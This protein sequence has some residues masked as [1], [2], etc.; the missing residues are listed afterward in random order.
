M[1]ARLAIGLAGL[2][3]VLGAA[4]ALADDTEALIA[5][6]KQWGEAGGKGDTATIAKLLADDLV[7]V[8]ETGVRGK[9]E[10]LA[11]NEP[12]PAGTKYEPTDF[13]VT[14]L[15]ANTAIMTHSTTGDD[16]HVS[17]HVWSKKSGAWQVVATS[18]TPVASE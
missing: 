1:R 15:D 6:D 4:H 7:S 8:T 16:A 13:K 12:A 14:F 10:E 17:L 3:L 5:L 11:D 2:L 9:K 18:T